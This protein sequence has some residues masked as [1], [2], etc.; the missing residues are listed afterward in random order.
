MTRTKT[1]ARGKRRAAPAPLALLAR[2]AR[3][4]GDD[5]Y[6]SARQVGAENEFLAAVERLLPRRQWQAFERYCLKATTDERINEALR[7]V[8]GRS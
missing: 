2:N 3:C 7:L 5:D 6:G 8:G 1:T 4:I